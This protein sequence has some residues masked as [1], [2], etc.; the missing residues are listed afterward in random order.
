MADA[1]IADEE[2]TDGPD[3]QQVEDLML[4]GTSMG[5]VRPRTEVEDMDGLWVAKFNRPDDR[6]NHARVEHAMLELAKA[7]GLMTSHSRVQTVG[8]RDVQ[9]VKRFDHEKICCGYLRARMISCPTII[10]SAVKPRPSGQG[11]K[12]SCPLT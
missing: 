12:A 1:V 3:A 2:I 7:C 9:L 6:W 5:G 4:I 11:Y 10:E 8:D